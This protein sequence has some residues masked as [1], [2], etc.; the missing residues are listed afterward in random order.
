MALTSPG[1]EVTII[2]ESQYAPPAPASVPFI[3]LATAQN[4]ANGS[5]TGV[6]TG[7][8]QSNANKLYRISS[9]RDLTAL[10]GNPFFYKT[11]TGT[12]IQGYELNEYGLMAAYSVLGL[13]NTVYVL[14]ADI[15]LAALVGR[16]TRPSGE[17]AD[18]T[19]WLNTLTSNCAS[20]SSTRAAETLH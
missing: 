3:L 12:P 13:T 8:L 5:G 10:F 18:G 15:D 1:I 17:P 19:Y 16:T 20:L 7:T 11:T 9:Q 2:D 14:R 6:A 4:K